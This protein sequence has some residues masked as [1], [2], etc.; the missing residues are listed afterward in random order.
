MCKSFYFK[1]YHFNPKNGQLCLTYQV[2]EQYHFTETITFPTPFNLSEN[3]KNVLDEIFFLL[4]VAFGI[5]Y[6]KAFLPPELIV[7]S[8][9]LSKEQATFF[10][11]LYTNGLGEFSVKNDV[12]LDIHFPFGDKNIKADNLDLKNRCL[13]PVGGGKD[14]CVTIE[15]LKKIDVQSSLISVGNPA[16]IEKCARQSKIDSHVVIKRILDEQ[17]ITLNQSGTVL[18]G[19]VPISGILAFVLWAAAVLYDYKY[20]VMSCERSANVGNLMRKGKSINHQYSKSFEF[21][22]DFARLTH[23]IVPDFRYF[24]VLRPISE[25]HIAKLF[26]MHCADYF[27]VFTSCNKAFKLDEGKRLSHWCCDCDKCRFVFLMLAVFIPKEKMM[28]IFGKNML[29]DASQIHGFEELLGLSGHKPFECV[30]EISESVYAMW[31]LAQLADWQNDVVVASFKN[32]L[33][34]SNDG[35]FKPSET[36]LIPKELI[37]VIQYFN[38]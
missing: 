35:L 16:P 31:Q 10:D 24:S 34:L 7:E 36:H 21:E 14:S 6:Y 32:R 3:K 27:D 23:E 26:S 11:K 13:I 20:V 18:N 19:H 28:H 4:H 30:G 17:L 1:N 37:N 8:G 22:M 5:S 15:L 29:D 38:I 33:K 25:I 2:D 9:V 12:D